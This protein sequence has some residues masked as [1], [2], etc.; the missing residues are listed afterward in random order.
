MTEVKIYKLPDGAE[1]READGNLLSTPTLANHSW[2][3]HPTLGA[4][5]CYT[6]L[7]SPVAPP[8]P[9][10]PPASSV[11]LDKDGDAWQRKDSDGRRWAAAVFTQGVGE[12]SRCDWAGLNDLYGPLVRL[13]P[14]PAADAPPLPWRKRGYD[15]RYPALVVE[16]ARDDGGVLEFNGVGLAQNQIRELMGICA[17]MLKPGAER[18]ALQAAALRS[19]RPEGENNNG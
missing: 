19:V 2:V 13:V 7:L 5:S 15:A 18:D 3:I 14:D 6:G 4:I 12:L 1:V 11:V 16:R 17:R 10:E 9:A 8:L